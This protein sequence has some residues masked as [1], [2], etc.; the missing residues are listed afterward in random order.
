MTHDDLLNGLNEPQRAAVMHVEGP[1]LVLAGPGS[2]KTRVITRRAAYLSREAAS[3]REILAITFTNKAAREM[4]ERVAHLNVGRGMTVCTFHALCA[5]LLREYHNVV[6]VARNFTILDRDDRRKLLKRAVE[7]AG[8][9]SGNWQPARIEGVVS[10]AKNQLQTPAQFAAGMGDWQARQIAEIYRVYE[11]MLAE[12]QGLDFDDLLMRVALG[13]GRHE[14][15]REELENR[16]RY[17]LIDEYQDTNA[18]QYQMARLLTRDRR[19]LCATGDPDQSIYGWRGADIGNILSFERDYPG[20]T[21]VRLEQNY[22]STKYILAAADALIARNERR[23]A[24]RLWTDNAE[25]A[26]V[27]VREFE[28][29]ED[30]AKNLAEEVARRIREGANPRDIAVF[31]R[32]NSLSRGIE[33]AMLRAGVPYQIARGVEF[34]NRKEIKDALA[35]L[36]V[37]LN[38]ADSIS[39]VRIL[40][41]PARGIGDTTEERLRELARRSGRTMFDALF[42]EDLSELGRSALKVRRFGELLR[43]MSGATAMRPAEA[44]DYVISHSGL[45]AF[46]SV[47]DDAEGSPISNLDELIS[48]A[49]QFQEENPEATL[50]DWL[51]L[52]SLQ[53]DVD[54]VR[55]DAGR[56]TLMTLHAAKG[57]EFDM[58]YLVG[59]EEGLLPF[60]RESGE[61]G[62]VEEERRLCFVGMT[63]ARKNLTLSLA[64]WR[65]LRGRATRTV[66]SPFLAELPKDALEREA[67]EPVSRRDERD[68]LTGRLPADI[69]EWCVGTVVRH[70]DHGVGRVANLTRAARLTHVD[71]EFR[72]GRR[73]HLI[74][75]HA[76]L[77]R[78][79]FDECD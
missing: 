17:V 11:K 46:Y 65:T 14:S 6:G 5:R 4:Q 35:Y 3:P 15:W 53:S 36:R 49:A 50:T 59:V 72:D 43:S 60:V 48:A 29:G 68:R 64:R 58:A 67:R 73:R 75:E 54:A 9:Q 32:I 40:N 38:P 69:D 33:E 25:G 27:V 61:E 66:R 26:R 62:D 20:A 18:A 56:V 30:E 7:E 1:L 28:T 52:A 8:L 22:R 13:L 55:D 45:R 44:V 39:L 78:V 74:L 31:Y 71:V 21:V 24:K 37:L 51:E 12:I 23:K 79:E 19:N 70:P 76:V 57:L 34:Y 63:R 41:T 77:Q 10:R 16:F 42:D 47:E 2:G